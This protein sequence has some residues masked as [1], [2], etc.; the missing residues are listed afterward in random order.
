MET[1]EL[2]PAHLIEETDHTTRDLRASAMSACDAIKENAAHTLSCATDAIR[3]QP[4]PMVVGAMAF[5]VAVGCLLMAGRQQTLHER[6]IE[7]PVDQAGDML[8]SLSDHLSRVIHQLK[9][10]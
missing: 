3:K 10:W 8:S 1:P 2:N 6:F 7:E 5:G 9:F 4:V